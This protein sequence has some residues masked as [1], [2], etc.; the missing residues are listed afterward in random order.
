MKQL[1]KFNLTV[2]IFVLLIIWSGM[3]ALWNSDRLN[4]GPVLC[5]FRALTGHTCPFCGSTR[6]IG[7][8]CAGNIAAAW[9]LNPF[10]VIIFIA[11]AAYLLKPSLAKTLN[12]YM[13]QLKVK[14]GPIMATTSV[15]TLFAATW[16]W[17][18][19]TRW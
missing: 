8:F 15:A 11:F 2:R 14:I 6:A 7:A 4:T 3:A 13:A 9:K 16:V 18:I 19:A 12:S 5:W 1:L 10:G 17:N